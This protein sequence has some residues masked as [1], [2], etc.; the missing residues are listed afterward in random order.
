MIASADE[1][2][3]RLRRAL[4]I[5]VLVGLAVCAARLVLGL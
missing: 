5:G 3:Y 4:V 1:L 2:R